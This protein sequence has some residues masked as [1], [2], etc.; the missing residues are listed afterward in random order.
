[1]ICWRPKCYIS[2]FKVIGRLVLKKMIL[3]GILLYI[4]CDPDPVYKLS[5]SNPG[6]RYM[7]M[8]WIGRMVSGEQMFENVD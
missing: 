1:M 2:N 5:S 3:K 4:S 8:A 7:D 6:R